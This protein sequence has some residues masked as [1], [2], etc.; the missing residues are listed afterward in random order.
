[1]DTDAVSSPES[2]GGDTPEVLL[3]N[4]GQQDE[5]RANDPHQHHGPDIRIGSAG[6]PVGSMGLIIDATHEMVERGSRPQL[7]EK[8]LGGG[9]AEPGESERLCCAVV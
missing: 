8:A 3:S 1:M 7:F 2:I 4:G 5:T 6:N 9:T